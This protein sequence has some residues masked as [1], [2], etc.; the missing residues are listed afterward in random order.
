M[1]LR[2]GKK[3]GMISAC[4]SVG[5]FVYVFAQLNQ[6]FFHVVEYF[7]NYKYP[8]LFLWSALILGTFKDNYK[9]NLKKQSDEIQLLKESYEQLDKDYLVNEKIQ[10][11]LKKQIISSEESIISLYDIASK[12]ET[13]QTEELYTETIGILSKYLKATSISIYYY[14]ENSNYLR[15]KISYGQKVENRKALTISDSK[16]FSNVVFNEQIVRWQDTDEDNFPLMSSPLIR[17][18]KVIAIVNIEDMDFDRLSDYAFQLFKL[19]MDWVNKSINQAIYIDEIKESKYLPE[20]NLMK[21]EFFM[22]RIKV[23]S[24]RAEEFGMEFGLIKY[25]VKNLNTH[26]ISER[27]TQSIRS[28]DIVS[29][30]VTSK[31]LSILVPATPKENLF[32]VENRISK[33]FGDNITKI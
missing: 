11:E 28:V 15:L 26:A 3:L 12:L 7:A 27:A 30:D 25:K 4:I 29:Y 17:N 5:F 8:L 23:E 24:R 16:G 31:I 2:Y 21:P 20:T 22:T 18:D 32:I 10:K 6:N 13:F 14:N 9:D 1:G 19:I 33:N